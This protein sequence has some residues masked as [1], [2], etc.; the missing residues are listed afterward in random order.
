MK[1]T[2]TYYCFKV[3]KKLINKKYNQYINELRFTQFKLGNI[4]T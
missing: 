2:E 3:A 4:L 1:I